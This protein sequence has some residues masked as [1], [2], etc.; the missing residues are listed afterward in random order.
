M[1]YHARQEPTFVPLH[2]VSQQTPQAG[3]PLAR[4][5]VVQN[6]FERQPMSQMS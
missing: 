2:Y 4:R 3:L 6:R 1:L 5:E